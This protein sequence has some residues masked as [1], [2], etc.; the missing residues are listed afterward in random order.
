MN[1]LTD[2]IL[3]FFLSFVA[4]LVAGWIVAM[5]QSI[6]KK[7]HRETQK[8]DL[9]LLRDLAE[10]AIM[11]VL[12]EIP[13]SQRNPTDGKRVGLAE[14][15]WLDALCEDWGLRVSARTK[16]AVLSAV[17]EEICQRTRSIS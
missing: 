5:I 13:T 2:I 4:S 16:H 17:K 10:I 1:E 8:K 9:E 12:H 3:K 7:L 11:R 15:K 6:M 14:L